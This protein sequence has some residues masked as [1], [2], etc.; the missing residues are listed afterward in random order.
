MATLSKHSLRAWYNVAEGRGVRGTDSLAQTSQGRR[1]KS[2]RDCV[3]QSV[4]GSTHTAEL[5]ILKL[6]S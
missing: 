4:I 6:G 3:F 5:R 2:R 1:A